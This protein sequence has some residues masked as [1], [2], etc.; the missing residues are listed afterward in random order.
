MPWGSVGSGRASVEEVKGAITGT[1]DSLF[2]ASSVGID[3]RTKTRSR[4]ATLDYAPCQAINSDG[5]HKLPTENSFDLYLCETG[6]ASQLQHGRPWTYER[7]AAVDSASN[8]RSRI[9][10]QVLSR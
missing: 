2:S 10:L 3:V 8:G 9:F 4:L 7:N 1:A 6:D 5:L